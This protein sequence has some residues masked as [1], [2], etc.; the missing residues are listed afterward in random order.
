MTATTPPSHRQTILERILSASV[1]AVLVASVVTPMEVVKVRLQAQAHDEAAVVDLNTVRSPN[2][3]P[4]CT[5]FVLDN[6]LME[7]ACEKSGSAIFVR[8]K[9]VDPASCQEVKFRNSFDALR[10]IVKCEGVG[11]LYNG[12]APTLWMAIPTT[13]MYFAAYDELKERFARRQTMTTSTAALSAG[14]FARVIAATAVAPFE[15]IRTKAQAAVNPPSMFEAFSRQARAQ[16]VFS[17]WRGLSPT[18]LRDVPFSA[19]YWVTVE[20]VKSRL[21]TSSS[22][23]HSNWYTSFLAGSSGGMLAAIFTHP[24]DVIKTRRQVYQYAISPSS[25]SLSG[26]AAAASSSSATTTTASAATGSTLGIARSI[27]RREGPG[28]LLVGLFPRVVKVVPST[29]I[30]LTTYDLGKAY[31][32]GKHHGAGGGGSR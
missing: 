3:C 32:A 24:F 26:E 1:G 31:F 11:A 22:S 14:A 23:P 8:G 18:L 15:L 16:G 19:I 20:S 29:A 17:F 10:W 5:H 21:A 9:F 4:K 28:G 6:G 27:I 7:H 2:Q 30:M 25:L 13:V 12:L